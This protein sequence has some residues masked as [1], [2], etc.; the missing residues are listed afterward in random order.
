MQLRA[1]KPLTRTS[2]TAQGANQD[3]SLYGKLVCS[4]V[5][6]LSRLVTRGVRCLPLVLLHFLVQRGGQPLSGAPGCRSKEHRDDYLARNWLSS[7]LE[8]VSAPA[9]HMSVSARRYQTRRQCSRKPR[10][11]ANAGAGAWSMALTLM[12]RGPR[13]AVVLLLKGRRLHSEPRGVKDGRRAP[14]AVG[15]RR[16]AGKGELG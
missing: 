11:H 3:V 2:Q 4:V 9:D 10:A 8:H 15:G 16:A 14:A 13:P 5:C 7:V 1:L 6:L 12:Q